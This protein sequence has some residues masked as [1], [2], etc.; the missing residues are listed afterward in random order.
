MPSYSE[1][2]TH[3]EELRRHLLSLIE[4]LGYLKRPPSLDIE[5]CTSLALKFKKD[6]ISLNNIK[7]AGSEIFTATFLY[8]KHGI[9]LDELT[10]LVY[11]SKSFKRKL[12]KTKTPQ[13]VAKEKLRELKKLKNV[14]KDWGVRFDNYVNF[15]VSVAKTLLR[16]YNLLELFGYISEHRPEGLKEIYMVRNKTIQS[17]LMRILR[18]VNLFLDTLLFTYHSGPYVFKKSEP[19]FILYMIHTYGIKAVNVYKFLE[20]SCTKAVEMVR[21][22]RSV[23]ISDIIAEASAALGFPIRADE[24]LYAMIV[25][26]IKLLYENLNLFN[27]ESLK[28]GILRL[29]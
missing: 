28:R 10:H 25:D 14:L 26:Q 2:K 16:K 24:P 12:K 13:A 1:M 4:T 9:S 3:V 19:T 21:T 6:I 22:Y 23:R 5:T 15:R 11:T 8:V 18:D 29:S 17:S 7:K 20:V 27:I